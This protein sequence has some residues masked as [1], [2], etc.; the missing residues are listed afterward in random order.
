MSGLG[1]SIL[2]E[3]IEQGIELATTEFIKQ[4]LKQGEAEEKIIYRH[5]EEN[6]RWYDEYKVNR[7][8]M[9]NYDL[10]IDTTSKT[11]KE[12]FEIVVEEYEK[13]LNK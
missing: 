9:S 1:A 12:V 7:D 2:E 10:V 8:D 5:E 13:W 3:G 6:K 4:M 11:P